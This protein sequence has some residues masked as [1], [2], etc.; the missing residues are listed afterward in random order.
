VSFFGPYD[1]ILTFHHGSEVPEH[2]LFI[3]SRETLL[4]VEGMANRFKW[5]HKCSHSM[6]L[7]F[8]IQPY[9]CCSGNV[10]GKEVQDSHRVPVIRTMQNRTTRRCIMSV[11]SP[12]LRSNEICLCYD[13]FACSQSALLE[14]ARDFTQL[15]NLL[16]TIY[17][18]LFFSTLLE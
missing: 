2:V 9:R 18:K 11:N 8:A 1:I 7:L 6:I 3:D 15:L 14:R 10:I 12:A 13:H 16:F 4:D 5:H 17:C